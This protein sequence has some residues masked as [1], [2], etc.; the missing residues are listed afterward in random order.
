LA[1]VHLALTRAEQAGACARTAQI[2]AGKS[3][4][5][6]LED[7]A[8]QVLQARDRRSAAAG[9]TGPLAELAVAAR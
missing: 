5:R 4:Y 7:R 3:G 6:R 8:V 1:E 9:S 2:L